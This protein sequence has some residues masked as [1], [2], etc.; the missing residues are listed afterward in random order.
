ML[1]RIIDYYIIIVHRPVNKDKCGW[2]TSKDLYYKKIFEVA[3]PRTIKKER[4]MKVNKFKRKRYRRKIEIQGRG[5]HESYNR[6]IK[7][8]FFRGAYNG[9]GHY[10]VS[11]KRY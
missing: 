1:S 11:I 5:L 9:K 3:I 6:D 2:N 7:R 4:K 10:T 8:N